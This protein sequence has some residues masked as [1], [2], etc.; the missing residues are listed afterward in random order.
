MELS[1]RI[2]YHHPDQ[3]V[4]AQLKALFTEVQGD[5]ARF[6]QIAQTLHPKHGADLAQDLIDSIDSLE[7]DA[8]AE[9]LHQI[10]NFHVCSFTHGSEGDEWLS[11]ILLFLKNLLP[12]IQA[13]GW[14]CGDDDPWEF[15]FKFDGNELIRQDDEPFNDPDED[16]EIKE[17][18]YIWWHA[19]LPEE[20]KV[21]FLNQSADED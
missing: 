14:G 19:G 11:L 20:I 6:I 1:T 10:G 16:K 15:W 12:D 18:I 9:T 7:Y 4:M 2:Y 13:L 5:E 3:N 17:R 21:G 8:G